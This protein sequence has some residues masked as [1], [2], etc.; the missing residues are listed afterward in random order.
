MLL[1]DH[2]AILRAHEL[3]RESSDA[4]SAAQGREEHASRTGG[5]RGDQQEQ[6]P[7][8]RTRTTTRPTPGAPRAEGSGQGILHGGP[9]MLEAEMDVKAVIVNGC[10]V[11]VQLNLKVL[12]IS[13]T[14]VLICAIFSSMAGAKE[15]S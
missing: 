12:C 14:T 6:W 15:V 1:H 9:K 11:L 10:D 13:V 2:Y 4:L 8:G 5:E 7:T 3:R